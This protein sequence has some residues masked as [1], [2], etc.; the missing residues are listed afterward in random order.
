MISLPVFIQEYI[1]KFEKNNFEVYV[2]GGAVRSLL[3]NQK[4]DN[5]DFTTNATPEQILKLFPDAYYNNT[6]GTVSILLNHQNTNRHFDGNDKKVVLE[7]TPFRKES[8]YQD[9][10]H[11]TKVKWAKTLEEDLARRDFTINAL[12]FNGKKI[13]DLFNGKKHLN[14]KQIVAVGDPDKRFSEDALRLI[15]AVRLASELGFLI[16]DKTRVSIEKNSEL[17]T[18]I[19]WERIRDELLKI[20]VS[21]H[22][23][24]GIIFLK[25]TGLLKYIIPEL[26]LC[27]LIPQ[28]SPLRHHIFDAGTHMVM[29]LKHCPSKDPITRLATLLH[30]IGKAKTF[31]K[32]NKTGLITFY[33]H[34]VVST[35]LVKNIA[36]RLRFSNKEKEKL[37]RLVKYH[38]FTVTE[39]ATNKAIRRFIRNV[40]KEYLQDMLDLRIG[41]RLGSGAKPT[42]W[43][44]ELFKKRLIEVQKEPFKISDLKIGG[45]DVMKILNIKPGPKVGQILKKIFTDVE[46]GRV[47]NDRELLLEVLQIKK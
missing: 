33:N 40:G 34:E 11:P 18:K 28:K 38:Q 31:W 29:S 7:L 21:D 3:L 45:K 44:L 4:V 39:M 9:S 8:D 23:A 13:I 15:R 41:D 2:V 19:S 35:K 20:I 46:Q 24:E 10:R 30:D 36:E 6:Y 5:W 26:D 47:K 32:D 42:S 25:N 14:S 16:E 27:F 43:R 1:D 12:A 17:I 37:T 22:P